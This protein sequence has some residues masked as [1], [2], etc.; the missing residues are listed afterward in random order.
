[1]FCIA[2]LTVLAVHFDDFAV[3]VQVDECLAQCDGDTCTPLFCLASNT[4]LCDVMEMF[5]VI[6]WRCLCS[7]HLDPFRF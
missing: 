7:V 6:S 3:F 5:C 4:F 2:A 1:M